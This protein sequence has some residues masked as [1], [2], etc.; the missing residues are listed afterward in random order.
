MSA[1]VLAA[2]GGGA[3]TS[4]VSA[5]LSGTPSSA[6]TSATADG[7]AAADPTAALA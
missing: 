4:S 2:T 6:A 5:F 1:T 7:A 3:D